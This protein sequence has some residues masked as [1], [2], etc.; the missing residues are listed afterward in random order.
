MEK[1][2]FIEVN[3]SSSYFDSCLHFV[4]FS[5]KLMLCWVICSFLKILIS[6]MCACD[7]KNTS[8]VHLHSQSPFLFLT[9]HFNIL[10]SYNCHLKSLFSVGDLFSVHNHEVTFHRVLLSRFCYSNIIKYEIPGNQHNLFIPYRK[11]CPVL[12]LF[13]LHEIYQT[14]RLSSY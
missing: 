1:L 7:L 14:I 12:S 8:V 4:I 13:I 9:Q 5:P 3:Q 2:K 10:L 11:L 6:R